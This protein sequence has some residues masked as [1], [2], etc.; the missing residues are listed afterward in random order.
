M[1]ESLAA[2]RGTTRNE[3]T[4]LAQEHMQHDL[5]PADRSKLKQAAGKLGTHAQI[6][7]VLGVGLGLLMAYRIRRLRVDTFNAFRVAEK[8]THIQFANGRLEPLPDLTPFVRPTTLGDIAMFGLFTA[9]GLFIGGETGLMTGI[10]SA[11]KTISKDPESKARIENAFGKLRADIL[12]RQ[13]D[14][15]DG[16]QSVSEK[17]SEIF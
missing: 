16:K 6:G 1:P 8:P 12:R 3:L 7:S 4:S 9:G 11:R 5:Q 17:I 15:L 14:K 13:A 10:Y 2:F